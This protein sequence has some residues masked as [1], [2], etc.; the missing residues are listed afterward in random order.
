MSTP[1]PLFKEPRKSC[2]VDNNDPA[3]FDK[4]FA[5]RP[6]VHR[7]EQCCRNCTSVWQTH[8]FRDGD[9]PADDNRQEL[10]EWGHGLQSRIPRVNP[11]IS[12]APVHYSN[13]DS[14]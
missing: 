8:L 7:E 6:G 14:Q 13:T 3:A 12:H 4:R 11:T 1:R 9:Y 10:R 5:N 2:I